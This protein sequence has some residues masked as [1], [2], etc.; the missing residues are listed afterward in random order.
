MVTFALCKYILNHQ[1]KKMTSFQIEGNIILI[2]ERR[3]Q[4]GV[5]E[6]ENGNI[7]SIVLNDEKY[8]Q[9]ILPGFVDAHVHVESSMLV[10]KEFGRIAP[11]HGMV[12]T[13]SDPHEIGNV[14]GVSGV[15]YMID[16]GKE[17]PFKFHF[18][19]PS[20]V[21][22]T[23]FETAGAVIDSDDIEKLLKSDDIYY[24]A[25]MMNYPGVMHKDP[26]VMRK[27]ELAHEIGKPVDGHAPGLRGEDAKN[28]I[29]AGITTDH[30]CLT[31]EEA[32]DKL[33]HNMKILI[34]EGSAAKNF[35]ALYTLIDEFPDMIMFCSDDKHPDDLLEGHINL[36]VKRALAKG[37]DMYNVLSAACIHP[38]E[39]YKMDIGLLREGDKADFIVVDDITSFN[40]LKTYIDGRLVAENGKTNISY[41]SSETIN[42]FN[43]DKISTDDIQL[44]VEGSLLNV[45]E[46]YDGQLITGKKEAAVK[47]ENG[48][49]ISDVE[50]DVLKMVV[51]N[52]YEK[53]APAVA[54]IKNFTLKEGAIASCVGHDSHN[55]IA[56]G[57]DDAS[58][59]DAINL[60]IEN[61]GG[62]SI[63]S[64]NM[65]KALALPIAGI[66][67]DQNA[68][69]VGRLYA[70][71]DKAA[72]NMGS[73]LHAPYMTLSFMALLVIPSL[74]L[75]D[76][77]LFDGNKFQFDSV[78]IG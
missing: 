74:K 71:L 49:A 40:V 57:A 64:E 27:I 56:V 73:T 43:I 28:Y 12:G 54:F 7:K 30:E 50:N 29:A 68:E 31:K 35:E 9:Y 70:E 53:Q 37:M 75:S 10:P 44:K 60:V 13:I 61:K 3:I 55:I 42:N 18:G 46:C 32:L 19:A 51:V 25:E 4:G 76:K 45:I 77:G 65:R 11:I 62:I 17:S 16:N 39:H 66:M 24:L 2:K 59:T 67:T 69:E 78:F 41:S 5:I 1:V 52:R 23:S 34:R 20:C 26:E 58:I 22:A 21:P 8:S 36:L 48:F 14:L 6:V 15:Q 33:Q 63:S 38:V 47:E 72:K